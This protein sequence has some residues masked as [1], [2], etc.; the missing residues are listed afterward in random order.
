MGT[1]YPD[2]GFL[3]DIKLGGHTYSMDN[4]KINSSSS[5]VLIPAFMAAYSGKDAKKI[6]MNPFPGFKSILPNWRIT[7]DGLMRIPL[8]KKLFKSFNLNHGYACTYNVGSFTSYSDWVSLGEGLGFTKD[9]LNP[10][11]AIPSS[12]YN[13]ASIILKEQFAPLFGVTVTFFNDLQLNAQYETLRTLTLNSSAGQLVKASSKT[14]N[15]G[16]SCSRSSQSS[17]M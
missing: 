14:F 13:I 4:G 2:R 11:G 3:R 12:P 7:Y 16:G 10:N 15:L 6:D 1:T 9:A 8:F 5:D 17:R